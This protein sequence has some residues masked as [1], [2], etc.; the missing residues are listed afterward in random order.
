MR[1]HGLVPLVG[2]VAIVLAALSPGVPPVAVRLASV[3]TYSYAK[4]IRQSVWVDTGRH[5]RVAADIIRPR[6]LDTTAKIPVIMEASPYN[7]CCGR[8]NQF[9]KKA[10]D[11]AGN[12]ITFPLFYDNYFVPRGYAVVLVDLAGTNRSQGCVDVG[13]PSDVRSATSVIDWLNGRASAYTSPD[14]STRASAYWSD[15]SVG[16]IGKSWDGTIAEG[17]AATGIAGLKT[18][19]PISA[20]SDWYDYFWANGARLDRESP[21]DLAKSVESGA[22]CQS[23]GSGARDYVASEGKVTASVSRRLG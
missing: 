23:V 2:A 15:G 8:G 7:G 4:A 11:A 9:Q 3:P 21:A 13:G 17:V 5:V 20:I 12:P 19:V 18:I 22:A 16:M 1:L 10:Y 14:G 6:E